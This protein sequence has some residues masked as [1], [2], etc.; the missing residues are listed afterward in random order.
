MMVRDVSVGSVG[1]EIRRER[2]RH[3]GGVNITK[4]EVRRAIK[5]K[6]WKS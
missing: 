6:K 3:I 2:N 1:L 4:E 5:L